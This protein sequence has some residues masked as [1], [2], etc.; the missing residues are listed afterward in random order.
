V[1]VHVVRVALIRFGVWLSL[2]VSAGGVGWAFGSA[3]VGMAVAGALSA[4]VLFFVVDT[5]RAPRPRDPADRRD[6]QFDPTRVIR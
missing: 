1:G 2:M 3:G 5:E 6:R 4:V